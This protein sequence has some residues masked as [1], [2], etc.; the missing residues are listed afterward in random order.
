MRQAIRI[1]AVA[2]AAI[3]FSGDVR[4][5]ETL[6]GQAAPE[7]PAWGISVKSEIMAR[8]SELTWKSGP[9][10]LPSGAR[11]AVLEGDPKAPNALFTIRIE[12]PAGYMIP[13]HFHAADEHVTVVSGRFDMGVGDRFDLARLEPCPA[14]SFMVMPAG[15]RHFALTRE[16]TVIQVHAVGPWVL[17]Y[18][19]P[20]DDPRLRTPK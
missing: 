5:E 6:G 11:V 13:A 12:F 4:G 17:T 18:V 14:G 9:P 15:R 2:V 20:A 16:P 8:P 1:S 7:R 19:N 3:A 10:A